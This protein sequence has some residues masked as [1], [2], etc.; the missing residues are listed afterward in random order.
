M[1][2]GSIQ[3]VG[4]WE[5]SY[6]KKL[7]FKNEI[8]SIITTRPID[9]KPITQQDVFLLVHMCKS[10]HGSDGKVTSKEIQI[11]FFCLFNKEPKIKQKC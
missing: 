5:H 1:Y 9:F 2:P 7:N 6:C 10:N 11:I 8:N 4:W 3:N